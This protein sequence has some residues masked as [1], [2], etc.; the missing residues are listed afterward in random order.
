M[1]RR[2]RRIVRRIENVRR[3]TR[4]GI[5]VAAVMR[6]ALTRIVMIRMMLRSHVVMALFTKRPQGRWVCF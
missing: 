3:S 5:G 2:K 1:I 6:L 4:D